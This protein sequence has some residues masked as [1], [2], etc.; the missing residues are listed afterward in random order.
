M[1]LRGI[2]IEVINKYL[3]VLVGHALLTC[4]LH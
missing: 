2:S 1:D 3:S 4:V